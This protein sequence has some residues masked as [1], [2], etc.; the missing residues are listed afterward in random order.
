MGTQP[1]LQ[2]KFTGHDA[3]YLYEEIPRNA[4]PGQLG[5]N[6]LEVLIDAGLKAFGI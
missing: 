6:P 1:L 5:H 3:F 4:R 2:D